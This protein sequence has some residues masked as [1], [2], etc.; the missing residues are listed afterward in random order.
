MA[1]FTIK[2]GDT[3]PALH[4]TFIHDNGAPVNLT[5]ATVVVNIRP[6]GGGDLLVDAPATIVGDPKDGVVEYQW[7]TGDTDAP[8]DYDA[9]WLVTWALGGQQTFPTN[10]FTTIEITADLVSATI[11]LPPL[12]EFCWPVDE[13]C[14]AELANYSVE[15]QNRAK[16]LATQTLHMLTGYRVGG[17]PQTVRP[18]RKDCTGEGYYTSWGS[19]IRL[20]NPVLVA[21]GTWLNIPCGCG[22]NPCGCKE[23]CEIELPGPVGFVASV[24]V[25]GAEVPST[26]YRVDDGKWLVRI[27]GECWPDCQDLEAGPF[28]AGA[29]SITYLQ[30]IPVDGLGAYAAGVLACE[31]AKA[32]SGGKCRLPSGVTSIVR[33]GVSYDFASGVFSD[34][35]TGI[36]EVDAWVAIYNPFHAKMASTVWTP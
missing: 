33:Q 27:D 28:D 36:R 22:Q 12:P 7:A 24:W 21:P 20:M 23:L 6:H 10:D 8:G 26:A 17:C 32:C 9:E 25:D 3:A 2:E 16:A 18:C 15:V 35:L 13:G 1:D 11:T 30:G 5:D 29:F 4:V 34:G 31:F 19:Y 14:C